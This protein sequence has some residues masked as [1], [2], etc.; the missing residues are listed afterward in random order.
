MKVCHS[1]EREVF[2]VMSVKISQVDFARQTT[3]VMELYPL[4][5]DCLLGQ[6]TKWVAEENK[7][8][9]TPVDPELTKVSAS[10]L[11]QCQTCAR[12]GVRNCP[13]HFGG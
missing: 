11:G 5:P 1:C 13:D 3:R 8:K 2:S 12:N 6:A 10:Y 4:C 9:S 7:N